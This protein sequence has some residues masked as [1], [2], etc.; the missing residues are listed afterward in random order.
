V[1][2][3]VWEKAVSERSMLRHLRMDSVVPQV[4]VVEEELT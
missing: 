1:V 3:V 2:E 4:F